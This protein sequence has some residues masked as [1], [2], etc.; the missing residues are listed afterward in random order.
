[1]LNFLKVAISGKLSSSNFFLHQHLLNF[2]ARRYIYENLSL[3]FLT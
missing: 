2:I 1:M 3:S